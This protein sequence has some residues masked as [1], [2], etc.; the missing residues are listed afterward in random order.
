MKTRTGFVSNSSSSSF[1][2]TDREH[3]GWHF[4]LAMQESD[5]YDYWLDESDGTV[6]D[7]SDNGTWAAINEFND[8]GGTE[9]E[10]TEFLEQTDF[11]G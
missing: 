5:N 3:P 8:I 7:S 9:Y 6:E 11:N 10:W 2:V 1:V 4:L